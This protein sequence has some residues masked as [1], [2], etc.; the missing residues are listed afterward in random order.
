MTKLCY[1][2]RKPH[3]TKTLFC[4]V[5]LKAKR[6]KGSSTLVIWNKV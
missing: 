4:R 2:C 1:Q 5:C 6:E 3:K